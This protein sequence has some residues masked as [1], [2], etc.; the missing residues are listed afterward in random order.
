LLKYILSKN[1]AKA[2]RS[3]VGDIFNRAKRRLFG[4]DFTD[5]SKDIKFNVITRPIEHRSDLSMRGIFE[6]AARA[7]GMPPNEKLYQ[8][9]EKGVEDYLDAHQQLAE[10][11]VLNA[12]QAYMHDADHGKTAADPDKVLKNVLEETFGKVKEDV[13]KVVDTEAT[14]VR[15]YST[16][17]AIS[18]L[19]SA[20][21]VD[22]PTVYFAGP[23]D[24]NTCKDCM[25][26]FFLED[27]L[28]PRVW[29]V[30]ELKNGYFK[31]G[32]TCPCVGATHPHCRH[33]LCSVLLGYGFVGGA[34]TYIE[35]GYDVYK[36]QRK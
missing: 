33:S 15:N 14:K 11:R 6:A 26:L 30:S 1:A 28:T 21:G 25:R 34:L 29:K 12:V 8:S 24:G 7:E 17:D 23:S 16:L 35:P 18:K 3:V 13:G 31:R 2:V 10:A 9:L 22:D 19:N 20:V 5:D 27:K 32:D 4:R 36:E